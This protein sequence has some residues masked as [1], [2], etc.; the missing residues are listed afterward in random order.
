M[1][2]VDRPTG[3]GRESSED[4]RRAVLG[5]GGCGLCL[6]ISVVAASSDS[7][8][9]WGTAWLVGLAGL[10]LAMVADSHVGWSD[11]RDEGVRTMKAVAYLASVVSVGVFL[12]YMSLPSTRPDVVEGRPLRRRRRR[13]A[14]VD[15]A[16]PV[17]DRWRRAEAD[18]AEAVLAFEDLAAE[19]AR[20]AAPGALV[21]R[22][23]RAAIEE[24]GHAAICRRLA[25]RRQAECPQAEICAPPPAPASSG[26]RWGAFRAP[27]RPTALGR[28]VHVPDVGQHRRR[29]PAFRTLALVRLAAE[30][31]EDGCRNEGRAAAEL[32]FVAERSRPDVA[33]ACRRLAREEEGHAELAWDILEWAVH[34]GGWPVRCTVAA[35][36]RRPVPARARGEGAGAPDDRRAWG[37]ID[38]P[39]RDA[40][41]SAMEVGVRERARDLL[42]A[43]AGR[44]GPAG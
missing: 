24:R 12:W 29:H 2:E 22:A 20:L 32:A 10:A 27:I 7:V 34:A 36:L 4:R 5:L 43:P 18:E 13:R 8:A 1:G 35:G 16:D 17:V 39:E 44:P 31:L 28:S 26:A 3:S 37:C 25:E 9:A 19:L 40:V 38:P 15:T 6:V 14:V 42:A 30:S 11:R 41:R 33:V 23:R 21:D